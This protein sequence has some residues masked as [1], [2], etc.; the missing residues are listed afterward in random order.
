MTGAEDRAPPEADRLWEQ[1]HP[2][3]LVFLIASGTA[4]HQTFQVVSADIRLRYRIGLT[5]RDAL[6]AAYRVADPVALLRGA[7][8]QV[9][10]GFFAG[11]TLDA[12]L[13]ENREA[14]A[15]RLQAVLAA[16]PGCGRKRDRAVPRGGGGDPPAGRCGG[17][18][19]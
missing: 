16:S 19:S 9:M 10:A 1:A 8:G 5:D 18:V 4:E 7:A 2:S 15:E 6:L 13:G 17:G 12:V 3:E 11:Q 14:I